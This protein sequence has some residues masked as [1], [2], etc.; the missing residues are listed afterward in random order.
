MFFHKIRSQD[1]SWV[2]LGPSWV[3]KGGPRRGLLE[4]KLGSKRIRKN[5]TKKGL[6][7]GGLGGGA[8]QT[9]AGPSGAGSDKGETWL[10]PGRLVEHLEHPKTSYES[11]QS[12]SKHF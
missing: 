12:I 11:L 3:A 8:G 5:E 7:L 2:D 6:V 1:A 10:P 4:T 9:V